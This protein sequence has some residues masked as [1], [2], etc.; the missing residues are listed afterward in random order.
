MDKFVVKSAVITFI[1][2]MESL[3]EE[4]FPAQRHSCRKFLSILV[5]RSKVGNRVKRSK[6]HKYQTYGYINSLYIN[7]M[8]PKPSRSSRL[9]LV[10]ENVE[11]IL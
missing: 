9:S 7:A 6:F 5:E 3:F 2:Q 4:N 11:S 8:H 10:T 1:K